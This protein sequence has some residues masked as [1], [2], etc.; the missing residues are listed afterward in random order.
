M[1][2]GITGEKLDTAKKSHPQPVETRA[3]VTGDKTRRDVAKMGQAIKYM[4]V[5]EFVAWMEMEGLVICQGAMP[6]TFDSVLGRYKDALR[7][8]VV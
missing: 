5:P 7:Q 2:L 4:G 8:A 3:Q 6:Q 1:D